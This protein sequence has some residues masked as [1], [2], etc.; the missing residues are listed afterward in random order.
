MSSSTDHSK[1]CPRL[2]P[3]IFKTTAT[4]D[5]KNQQRRSTSWSHR[6]S[7]QP[8]NPFFLSRRPSEQLNGIRHRGTGSTS[9]IFEDA[10]SNSQ[11]TEN[12]VITPKP[13]V[14]Y[15]IGI[16]EGFQAGESHRTT[17][18]SEQGNA[19]RAQRTFQ[20][21]NVTEKSYKAEVGRPLDPTPD[22]KTT[23]SEENKTLPTNKFIARTN[24]EDSASYIT[25]TSH[26]YLLSSTCKQ[27]EGTVRRKIMRTVSEDDYLLARGANPRTGV[28]TPSV[29]S[30]SSS[31]DDH[32]LFK[33]REMSQNAKWRLKGDQWVSLGLDQPSP[34]PTSPFDLNSHR[35]GRML[36]TPP[37]LG[38]GRVPQYS[39]RAHN[40]HQHRINA[41]PA[42][43]QSNGHPFQAGQQR[44]RAPPTSEGKVNRMEATVMPTR[45][46][47]RANDRSGKEGMLRRKPLG[48]PPH[49]KSA[50]KV[51]QGHN[52]SDASTETVITK[53]GLDPQARSPSMP[54][55]QK[56]RP[57]RHERISKALPALPALPDAKINGDRNIH[58]N[59]TLQAIYS[60][61]PNGW[62]EGALNWVSSNS[63]GAEKPPC[64]PTKYAP[65]RSH[66]SE[67]L[68]MGE[69][70]PKPIAINTK[71]LE[72]QRHRANFAAEAAGR[73][74]APQHRGSITPPRQH[75]SNQIRIS[76]RMLEQH[77]VSN[78]PS[79]SH[80]VQL[81]PRSLLQPAST[82]DQMA[83]GGT[84][85]EVRGVAGN[86]QPTVASTTTIQTLPEDR[87]INSSWREVPSPLRPGRQ[88]PSTASRPAMPNR[89]EGTHSVPQ[90]SPR[91][92]LTGVYPWRMTGT[93]NSD[94]SANSTSVE[95]SPERHL[96]PRP[97]R[98]TNGNNA[99]PD[100]LREVV[101]ESGTSCPRCEE[102]SLGAVKHQNHSPSPTKG[103]RQAANVDS[104]VDLSIASGFLAGTWE[105]H[106]G[107]CG[108]CC[109]VGCH[110]SCLGHR[111]PST[112]KSGSGF[113]NN[114]GAV[115]EAVRNSMRLSRRIRVRTSAGGSHET[116]TEEVA[117]LETPM[118]W[119]IGGP[120]SLGMSSETYPDHFWGD[121]G[122]R[123][124]TKHVPPGKRVASNAS[125]STVKTSDVPTSAGIIAFF[126]ALTV[127]F[128]AL[129]MWLSKH[130]QWLALIQVLALKLLEMGRHVLHTMGTVYRVA[131][132]YS[133]TGR[134][135]A[136]K[137]GSLG[138][139]VRDCVKAVV[140]SLVLVAVAM[141]VG[142]VLA[143]FARAGN[144]LIWG[145]GW[146]VW[147]VKAVGLG[148]LW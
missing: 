62:V 61:G 16:S 148:I 77:R 145:L 20:D 103:I 99:R 52:D 135:S 40:S 55:L 132:I 105:D 2:A 37:K 39:N 60:S 51:F 84:K 68:N 121:A 88:R 131:Y 58:A 54:I 71:S 72:D 117:E 3:T 114:L 82:D 109:A 139:L 7:R 23:S 69:L 29:H 64:P 74:S 142:R 35:R 113:L 12:F 11:G 25:N 21:H 95:G 8:S 133:K 70:P 118:S 27:R 46:F 15:I 14:L 107:C 138:G 92:E 19:D 13:D 110:G 86:S 4:S 128:G 42:A 123:S 106:S 137:K 73:S 34:L 1:N 100:R 49:Q 119:E 102:S 127:P 6:R 80:S 57:F 32:E 146:V 89:A 112:T 5:C 31:I 75:Q 45:S 59:S 48:T 30:G 24:P 122:G 125:A 28:V 147:I 124:Q 43:S 65:S 120:V 144:W 111:S 94:I 96:M 85:V 41:L 76:E 129:S 79:S 56:G 126:E 53:T 97:L 98:P 50:G 134:I 67:R 26:A 140:F 90:V 141:M 116:E 83:M 143:V 18:T 87:L 78:S 22:E 66:G 104:Q 36:R 115:K 81:Q 63:H 10:P 38:P 44:G 136:G 9:L 33:I 17:G 108:E 91:K 47:P 101:A 93:P 130:P